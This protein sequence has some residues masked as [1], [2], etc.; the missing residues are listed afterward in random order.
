MHGSKCKPC[1]ERFERKRK[2]ESTGTGDGTVKTGLF[3]M[4]LGG[5]LEEATRNNVGFLGLN[6]LG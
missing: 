5:D 2:R 1:H 6:E 3:W 4:R